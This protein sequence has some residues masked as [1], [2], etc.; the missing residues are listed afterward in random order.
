M[1]IDVIDPREF[2]APVAVVTG[3]WSLERDRSLLS[4]STVA[5]TLRGLGVETRMF[6][7]W[8]DRETLAAGLQDTELAFLAIAG[9]GAE[10]GRLQGLLEF[11]GVP[12]T[13]SG[14]F[15]SAVGMHKT[16]A[17]DIVSARGVRVAAGTPV[18]PGTM[19]EIEARRI[20]DAHGLPVIVKPV[21][22]GGSIGLTLAQTQEGL[23]TVIRE[24]GEVPMMAEA[25]VDGRSVS[26]GI[27]Q[28]H[29]GALHVLPPLE[30]A[31]DE[32]VYSFRAKRQQDIT[33]YH[34][35]AQFPEAVLQDLEIAA[36]R[37][38]LALHCHG[39]SRHDFVV[40]AE[41]GAVWLEVNTLPGLSR[42]GNLA[43]MAEA[44]G[45]SYEQL[46]AHIVRSARTDRRRQP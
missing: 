5:E 20:A 44:G 28:D 34:C 40:S 21:S 2:A 24:A 25:Y 13:G 43:R 10:D 30:T 42:Q 19:P 11:L 32:G 27:L 35:P 12:Y 15:A 6:D 23:A 33:T 16:T 38:H 7:L 36:R 46:L 37:A 8:E 3:G 18:V 1:K 31:T 41:K 45:L 9:R 29:D 17:K 39:Y 4:G 22:E 26:V 14:V